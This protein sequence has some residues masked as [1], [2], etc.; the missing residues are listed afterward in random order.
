MVKIVRTGTV[1]NAEDSDLF[2][3]IDYIDYDVLY[4]QYCDSSRR[5][6]WYIRSIVVRD[7][8]TVSRLSMIEL[9]DGIIV[10]E[11]IQYMDKCTVVVFYL[12]YHI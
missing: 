3:I 1:Y 4:L 2:Q 10:T 6:S 11:N 7:Y 5:L 8:D 12:K 9:F